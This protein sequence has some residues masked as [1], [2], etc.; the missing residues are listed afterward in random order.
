MAVAFDGANIWVANMASSNTVTKLRASDGANLGT[1]NVGL[2]NLFGV[3]FDGTNIWVGNS[4]GG[5]GTVTKLRASDGPTLGT[6]QVGPAP[7]AWPLTG[8]IFG[9]R[10]S[11]AIPLTSYGL[12]TAPPW[13]RS[14]LAPSPLAWPSTG[15]TSG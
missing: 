2:P 3:A 4:D 6:F 10:T 1:F 7:L 5:S 15:Q 9:W 11:A 13:G 8:Q 14:R 12:P